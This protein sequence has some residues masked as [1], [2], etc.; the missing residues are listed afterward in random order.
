MHPWMHFLIVDYL[1][2][3]PNRYFNNIIV[4]IWK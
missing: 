2:I 4:S 3:L 1:A